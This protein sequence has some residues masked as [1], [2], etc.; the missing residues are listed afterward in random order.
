MKKE[1]LVQLKAECADDTIRDQIYTIEMRN[2]QIDPLRNHAEILRRKLEDFHFDFI[3]NVANKFGNLQ[4]NFEAKEAKFKNCQK[5]FFSLRRKANF[6]PIPFNGWSEKIESSKS[7]AQTT[8]T[9]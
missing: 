4:Q 1:S 9:P 8:R 7:E 3:V 2:G 6:A 5:K